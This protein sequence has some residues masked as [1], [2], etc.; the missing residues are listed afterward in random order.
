MERSFLLHLSKLHM[1]WCSKL[2]SDLRDP[3]GATFRVSDDE[4]I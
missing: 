3:S 1:S 2:M 4:D